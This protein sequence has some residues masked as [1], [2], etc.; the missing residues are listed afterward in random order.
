VLSTRKGR[1]DRHEMEDADH[2]RLA[3]AV[4]GAVAKGCK[5]ALSGYESPIYRELYRGWRRLAFDVAFHATRHASGIRRTEVLWCSYPARD[6][7]GA[8]GIA[9]PV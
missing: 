8:E 9:Q 2:R 1:C 6:E 5:V 7:L 4:H 3:A